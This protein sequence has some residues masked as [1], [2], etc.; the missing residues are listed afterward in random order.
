MD[1]IDRIGPGRTGGGGLDKEFG[2]E[3]PA[4]EGQAGYV[5][6][7][8]G[9][10]DPAASESYE[11]EVEAE[12]SATTADSSSGADTRDDVLTDALDEGRNP[13]P[14]ERR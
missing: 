3:D 9:T 7:A 6:P 13:D 4:A 10:A 2:E 11:A 14:T 12:R 5:S 1:A 8:Q